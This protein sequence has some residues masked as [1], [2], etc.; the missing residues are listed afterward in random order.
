MCQNRPPATT[1]VVWQFPKSILSL[2]SF[3]CIYL[4]LGGNASRLVSARKKGA[5]R[6][7][8]I[9]RGMQRPGADADQMALKLILQFIR[10]GMVGQGRKQ[11]RRRERDSNEDESAWGSTGGGHLFSHSYSC[12]GR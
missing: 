7:N 2:A 12:G 8:L 6:A 4:G 10:I 11:I 1:K 5:E 3:S 9:K